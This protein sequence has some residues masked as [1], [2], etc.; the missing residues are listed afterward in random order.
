MEELVD[1]KNASVET[2]RR[3]GSR[4]VKNSRPL[5]IR[6]PLLT[7]L[8]SQRLYSHPL[9]LKEKIVIFWFEINA[10]EVFFFFFIAEYEAFR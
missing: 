10:L 2:L 3:N 4:R 9:Q 7:T 1:W 8:D 5:I 6:F